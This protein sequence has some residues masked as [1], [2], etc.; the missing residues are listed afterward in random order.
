MAQ[1][2]RLDEENPEVEPS[3]GP[4]EAEAVRRALGL[5]AFARLAERRVLFLR[6][7]IEETVADD[8]VAQ[9]LLLDRPDESAPITLVIDSPGGLMSGMFALHDTMRL[10]RSPV[11]TLCVGMAASAAAFLLCTPTGRR[12]ITPNA[13]VMI[14]QPSGQSGG[15]S[16]DIQTQA[17][18]MVE[19]RRRMERLMAERSGQPLE[20]LQADMARDHWL[21]ADDAL[22]YG[23]VDE[24][25]RGPVPIG[26]AG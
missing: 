8:L 15:T 16:A 24:V 26:A 6:G 11:D 13:S 19:N 9:M 5:D 12:R 3:P 20:R 14:H 22:G 2:P 18:Q 17:R 21:D 23:L 4:P 7:A 10:V 25:V 1:H